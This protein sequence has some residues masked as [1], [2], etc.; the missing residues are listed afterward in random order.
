MGKEIRDEVVK[1]MIESCRRHIKKYGF[2]S[3]TVADLD[4]LASG[5]LS[6]SNAAPA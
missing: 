5:R 4:K 2:R 1:E 6:P 3:R